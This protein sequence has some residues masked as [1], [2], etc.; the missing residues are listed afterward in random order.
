MQLPVTGG[1]PPPDPV[2]LGP[3]P[4]RRV[5]LAAGLWIKLAGESENGSRVL[6]SGEQ[7]GRLAPLLPTDMRGRGAGG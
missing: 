3:K 2:A 1:A 7:F 5:F 6:L 4:I